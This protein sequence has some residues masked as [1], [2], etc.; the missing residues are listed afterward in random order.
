MDAMAAV[1]EINNM[2]RNC[3]DCNVIDFRA[4][5]RADLDDVWLCDPCFKNHVKVAK[6]ES[7]PW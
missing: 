4:T 7:L 6:E 1:W 3:C 2:Q 5:G